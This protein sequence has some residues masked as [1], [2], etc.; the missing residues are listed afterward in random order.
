MTVIVYSQFFTSLIIYNLLS[1]KK[2]LVHGKVKTSI[3]DG[4]CLY[5]PK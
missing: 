4:N 2:K 5:D 3:I 1:K